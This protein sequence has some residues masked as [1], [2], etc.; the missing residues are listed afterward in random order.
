MS[1]LL[2]QGL[3]IDSI[4]SPILSIRATSVECPRAVARH[5]ISGDVLYESTRDSMTLY[6]LHKQRRTP[7]EG[8]HRRLSSRQLNFLRS[9]AVSQNQNEAVPYPQLSALQPALRT[10]VRNVP[11]RGSRSAPS[12]YGPSR[13]C[14]SAGMSVPNSFNTERG[15]RTARD[16]YSRDLYLGE[17]PKPKDRRCCGE[18]AT[19][20]CRRKEAQ[21]PIRGE[22]QQGQRIAATLKDHAQFSVMHGAVTLVDS[23]LWQSVSATDINAAHQ[24]LHHVT[25]FEVKPTCYSLQQFSQA[26]AQRVQ[27]IRWCSSL[28]LQLF[29]CLLTVCKSSPRRHMNYPALGMQAFMESC[30]ALQLPRGRA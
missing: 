1:R 29:G 11:L 24:L 20:V 25:H 14:M 26:G 10:M 6:V 13:A 5:R 18:W 22:P 8:V 17:D 16:L 4:S 27:T 12:N 19:C 15:S 3:L 2:C 7:A 30:Q 28:S 23:R 21:R 9:R